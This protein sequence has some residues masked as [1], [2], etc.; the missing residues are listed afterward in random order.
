MRH[1]VSTCGWIDQQLGA[2]VQV[3]IVGFAI[4]PCTPDDAQPGSNRVRLR[5]LRSVAG[6]PMSVEKWRAIR[7]YLAR[8]TNMALMRQRGRPGQAADA[9]H[10]SQLQAHRQPGA[11][12]VT[13]IQHAVHY[14]T[15]P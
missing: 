6:Q 2:C 14:K 7:A 9:G 4:C 1:P 11:Q 8:R 12:L 15:G 5:H 10:Q 13:W 3:G